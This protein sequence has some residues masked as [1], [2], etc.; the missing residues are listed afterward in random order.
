MRARHFGVSEGRAA[1]FRMMRRADG[2]QLGVFSVL[3]IG[4]KKL[5]L[6]ITLFM[7][8]APDL[9]SLRER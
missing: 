7:G 5:F 2:Q 3:W 6:G 9:D 4:H 8:R 1:I